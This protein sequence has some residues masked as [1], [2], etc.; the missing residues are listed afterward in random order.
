MPLAYLNH[1]DLRTANLTE[2]SRLYER[3]L[4]LEKGAAA[5]VSGF[6]RCMALLRR[7]RS[8]RFYRPVCQ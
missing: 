1:V 2:M 3:V 5:A 8:A 4:A 6:R 7:G